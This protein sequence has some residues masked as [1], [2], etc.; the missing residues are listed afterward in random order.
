MLRRA[1]GGAALGLL[2]AGALFAHDTWLL[3]DRL[4]LAPGQGTTLA[5]TSGMA[6]PRN[7]TAI[8]PERVRTAQ[9]R[10][11][12]RTATLK[13]AGSARGALRFRHEFPA[14]GVATL[15]VSLA[16][17]DLEL[18][19]D[20]VAHYLDEIAAP[21]SVRAAY[22]AQPAPRRWRERY[23]KHAKTFVRVGDPAGDRSWR[24]PT[25]QA[26]ELVPLDDPTALQP[27]SALTVRVL[28][29]GAPLAGFPVGVV[30]AGGA[31]AAL[32][33]ADAEGVLRIALPE[34]GR[35]M[36]RGTELR[37]GT[38]DGVDWESDFATLTLEV[39]P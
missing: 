32:V 22:E 25:G 19:P 2:A 33:R 20:E 34:A 11:A 26:L 23:A 14:A 30:R 17:R 28:R 13:S 4:A 7:E 9:V 5:L 8:R 12:G 6:F 21:D 1:A 35:W 36:L 18:A 31:Q 10:L 37:R 24:E 27:G 29:G 16:P 15:W 39:R 3:P 38:A